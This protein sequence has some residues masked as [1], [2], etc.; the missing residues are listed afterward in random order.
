MICKTKERKI[1]KS[2]EQPIM[3]LLQRLQRFIQAA[4]IYIVSMVQ[5]E[6]TLVS[7]VHSETLRK[8]SK[9]VR[10][11]KTTLKSVVPS[12]AG[13]K[14]SRTTTRQYFYEFLSLPLGTDSE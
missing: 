9:T 8:L 13:S 6:M 10:V 12:P 1:T 3:Q 14:V 11:V 7:M 2:T 4:M 5:V